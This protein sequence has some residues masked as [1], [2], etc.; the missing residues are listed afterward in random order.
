[1]NLSC[2]HV[3]GLFVSAKASSVNSGQPAMYGPDRAID[4]RL[5]ENLMD[6]FHSH[7]EPSPW[8][9]VTARQTLRVKS[10]TL[11]YR[12][13]CCQESMRDVSVF[14]T[15][16]RG[17]ERQCGENFI[18]PAQSKDRKHDFDC[19]PSAMEAVEITVRMDAAESRGYLMLN[20]ITAEVEDDEQMRGD[21]TMHATFDF[22]LSELCCAVCRW[23]L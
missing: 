2:T 19:G 13:D 10:V 14:L 21:Y 22:L 8:I 17:R 4:G 3:A 5:S 12:I 16:G 1:M 11:F 23:L 7:L 6:F 9:K 20:E 15:D 18:G